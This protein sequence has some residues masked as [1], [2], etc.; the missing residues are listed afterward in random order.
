M[1]D[2]NT[3]YINSTAGVANLSSTGID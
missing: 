1:S 2:G 3:F